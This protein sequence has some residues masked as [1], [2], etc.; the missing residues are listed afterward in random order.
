VQQC[1]GCG[2]ED[3]HRSR[4]KSKWESWR[5]EITGK[6]LYRCRACGWRGW[7]IDQGPSLSNAQA[8]FASR[9][10]APEPPN[11]K[12]TPLARDNQHPHDIDL[13][14]LDALEPPNDR[15]K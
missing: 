13:E 3:I 5:K 8:D 2:S 15:K 6:R 12:G 1:P 4:A 7:G 10:L 14:A 11:L 9:A